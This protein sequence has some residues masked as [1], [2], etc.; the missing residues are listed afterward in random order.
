M[1]M[2]LLL[3]ILIFSVSWS[4]CTDIRTFAHKIHQHQKQVSL[5]ELKDIQT[6]IQTSM[7]KNNCR[8]TNQFTR[9]MRLLNYKINK[10]GKEKEIISAFD[11]K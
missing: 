5:N 4:N 1:K 7:K 6:S 11:Y 9:D 10:T 8:L 3:I 2:K